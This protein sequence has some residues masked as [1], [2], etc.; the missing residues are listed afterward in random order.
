MRKVLPV[1]PVVVLLALFVAVE[2]S[3]GAHR[4]T[5]LVVR[6]NSADGTVDLLENGQQLELIVGRRTV[7]IDDQGQ[8]LHT[9]E[10]LQVGDYV[11]EECNRRENGPS[12][13]RNIGVLIPAWRMLESPEH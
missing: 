13:A 6:V 5:G 10:T 9:I 4:S 1:L 3:A 8:R 11:R 7:L 2:A 12:I